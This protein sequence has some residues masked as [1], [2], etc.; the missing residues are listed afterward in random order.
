MKCRI[1]Y[2]IQS[3]SN[4]ARSWNRANAIWILWETTLR[5]IMANPLVNLQPK[6]INISSTQSNTLIHLLHLSRLYNLKIIDEIYLYFIVFF[7]SPCTLLASIFFI[8]LFR[9]FLS[10]FSILFYLILDIYSVCFWEPTDANDS[11]RKR[12]DRFSSFHI[13]FI[14]FTCVV[15]VVKVTCARNFHWILIP[16]LCM[17]I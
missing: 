7:C 1:R 6:G 4:I 5:I 12:F 10:T 15:P 14:I 3:S 11:R 9:A 17:C 16:T 13:G 8:L 2:S